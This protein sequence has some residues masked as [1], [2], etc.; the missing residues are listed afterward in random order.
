MACPQPSQQPSQLGN[1]NAE[2]AE[3]KIPP[4]LKDPLRGMMGRWLASAQAPSLGRGPG[5]VGLC[6]RG[7][8][9]PSEGLFCT[10]T[11]HSFQTLP[12]LQS[13]SICLSVN[14]DL[15]NSSISLCV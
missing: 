9:W 15:L 4:I 8:L 14:K 1:Q 3:V 7:H 13:L 10:H 11:H 2:N 6:P 5:E 12:L